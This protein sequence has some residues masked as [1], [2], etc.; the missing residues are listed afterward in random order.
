MS[1]MSLKMGLK[2]DF[3]RNTCY[4][5]KLHLKWTKMVNFHDS[6][7]NLYKRIFVLSWT[8]CMAGEHWISRFVG[9]KKFQHRVMSFIFTLHNLISL[10]SHC[11]MYKNMGLNSAKAVTG[12][13]LDLPPKKSF[14][15]LKKNNNKKIWKHFTAMV[16]L[17]ASVGYKFR[18][19]KFK[20]DN[21]TTLA[22][23][24]R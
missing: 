11:L 19:V 18:G 3:E 8:L 2:F 6:F 15:P 20:Y 10:N 7:N 17:S 9:T 13:F 22:W 1:E 5:E 21:L 4:Q 12:Y 23:F 14:I 24:F 16:I